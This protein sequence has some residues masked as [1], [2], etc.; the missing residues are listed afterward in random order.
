MNDSG[1]WIRWKDIWICL[2]KVLET[3]FKWNTPDIDRFRNLTDKETQR[4]FNTLTAVGANYIR[5]DYQYGCAKPPIWFIDFDEATKE[6]PVAGASEIFVVGKS[7]VRAQDK[8][9][10]SSAEGK[11]K[12]GRVTG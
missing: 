3:E 9:W 4:R 1:L 7:G 8:Y 11:W 5:I 6:I 12:G 2:E 10:Y